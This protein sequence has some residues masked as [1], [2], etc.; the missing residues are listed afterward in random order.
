MRQKN[1]KTNTL[2]TEKT[3]KKKFK[4]NATKNFNRIGM[5]IKK[6]ITNQIEGKNKK[7][8]K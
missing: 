8:K 3:E 6:K 1:K 2:K 4:L 7:A 5:K